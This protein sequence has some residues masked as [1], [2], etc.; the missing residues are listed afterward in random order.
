MNLRAGAC[1]LVLAALMW[2]VPLAPVHAAP[3]RQ[4]PPQILLRDDFDDPGSG[5][6]TAEGAFGSAGYADGA[7]VVEAQ[8]DNLVW[9]RALR[10]IDDVAIEVDATQ[11]QGPESGDNSY[12]IV[13]RY[14]DEGN[15][16]SFLVSAAGSYGILRVLDGQFERILP[17]GQS[18]AIRQGDSTNHLTAVCSQDY[19]ALYANGRLLGATS[20]D[21]LARGDI[22]LI[23]ATYQG[24]ATRVAFDNLVVS[25]PRPGK[26]DPV[27]AM[28]IQVEADALLGECSTR[29][30][31]S[32]FTGALA[33]CEGAQQRYGEIEDRLGEAR[34]ALQS[35]LASHALARY[36]EALAAYERALALSQAIGDRQGI[37]AA[38][39]SMGGVY[40]ARSDDESA[41]AA[42]ERALEI[43]QEI[44]DRRGQATTLNNIGGLYDARADH[45][46]ALSILEQALSIWQEVGDT[47]GE[48]TTLNNIGEV[49][50]SLSESTRAL[51]YYQ[52]ALPLMRALGDRYGEAVLLDNIGS[53]YHAQSSY[54]EAL[55]Y[56]EQALAIRQEIGD[57]RGE[58]TTLGNIGAVH[59]A[60]SDDSAALSDYTQAL[61]VIQEIGNRRGEAR[62]LINVG[63]AHYALS[64]YAEA[65]DAQ[66]RALVICRE[67]GYR[68]GE[69]A[70]LNNSAAVHLARSEYGAALTAFEQAL[71]MRQA[72]GDRVGEVATLNGV[73]T[74]RY[75]LSEYDQ[76]LAAYERALPI[77]QAVGDRAGE[78]T[79]L[80]NTSTV[81]LAL[82]DYDEALA[83]LERALAIQQEIGNRAGEASALDGIGRVHL[84]RRDYEQALQAFERGLAIRQAIG[85][86]A[87]EATTLNNIGS[88]YR[89]LN[90]PERALD[91]HRRALPLR[92]EIGDR[93]GEATTLNNIGTAYLSLGEPDLA[94][95][96]LQEA[97]P[98]W[99]QAGHAYGEAGTLNNVAEADRARGDE[100]QALAAYQQSLEILRTAGVQ[101]EVAAVLDNQ[102]QLYL[103]LGEGE[104]AA[105]ALAEA[106]AIRREIGD[107]VGQATTLGNLAVLDVRQ[108]EQALATGR[109][110]E[111]IDLL[112]SVH[113]GLKA[114]AVQS[115]FAGGT[116]TYYDAAVRLLLQQ[117]REEEAFYYAERARARTLLDLL[118]NQR[119]HPKAGED[120]GLIEKEAQQRGELAALEERLWEEWDKPASERSQEAIDEIAARLEVLRGD[121]SALLTQLELANPEYAAL[122]SIDALTLEETQALLRSKAPGTTLLTY[123]VGQDQ[124]ILFLVGPNGSAVQTVSVTRA[125]LQ[126]QVRALLAQ[127]KADPLLPEGWQ[128][129]A[130]ALYGWLIELLQR[131]LPPA[132]P[133]QPRQ[134][135]IVPHDLLH[136][137]PYGLLY[138][139]RRTLL[140]G[141]T[142]LYLPSAS[143][144]PY[145]L[146]ERPA[147]AE[148]L[149]AMA[150]PE[151]PG[152]PQLGSAVAEAERVAALYGTQ[153][154]VGV[155]AS[156]SRF[157]AQ[158]GSYN[159]L[160]VAVHSDY[161]LSNPL[162][163]A[164]VLQAGEGED[165]RLEVH[166]VFDLDLPQA[167]LVVL[168]AC[169]THLAALSEGDELVGLERAFLRA[170]APSLVTTLWP[171]DDAATAA[172][173]ERFY[174]HLR[175][176]EAKADALRLAQ[177][178]T[179]AEHP[180]PYYWAGFVLVGDGGPGRLPPS[181]WP[182]WVGIGAAA[183]C[184]LAATAWWWRGKAQAVLPRP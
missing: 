132:R 22:A 11:L 50:R 53:A 91:Y 179:R 159:L 30:D 184:G 19:L 15:F 123:Y 122:V 176:G 152:A 65:L 172:L 108:G 35:G 104:Q 40:E 151:A 46:K 175:G 183:A 61:E 79:A 9:G 98:I 137:L 75:T 92:R 147:Q 129:P 107:R 126:G 47:R 120:P 101:A 113:A 105:P 87:G 140:E 54:D 83:T 139:G 167:D 48:A 31:G 13:C 78:A 66:Q 80:S 67:I 103:D 71:Q 158:A 4:Q 51:D 57:R 170:G 133:G 3:P 165:G 56:Y 5:W 127:L 24:R 7:Y 128:A 171:V 27:A 60:Q 20:D 106:L 178:E 33:A 38:Y 68:E 58:A 124:L 77:A 112:E 2:L 136:Y 81:Y 146:K 116:S 180:N 97:L 6:E 162:F 90:Q 93:V 39:N 43:R 73:G 76:A 149:L 89:E 52:R 88:T 36:D 29:Y 161:R 72:I 135:A 28:S 96:S 118:G 62:T 37:A 85:D 69:A 42:Y 10:T 64:E 142:L 143:S 174:V 150:H 181:R 130:Q 23:A 115:A 14:A 119:V 121:Y 82:A 45:E 102:G 168:S 1:L 156:E 134:L 182:L 164:I 95:A 155:D 18:D 25:E 32:D 144:L 17:S 125:E 100:E 138:D 111:A 145:I 117:G 16:Y 153:P 49:H 163:S 99:R 41:L 94:L 26:R 131:Y 44:G 21:A 110:L 114:E 141:Y 160:H 84:A 169:E 8:Q 59:A 34:A 12:G 157:K 173:M 177:L 63:E 86:R 70:A 74:V 148:T 109:V 154:L 166:E 55:V